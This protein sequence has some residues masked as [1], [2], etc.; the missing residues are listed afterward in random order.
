MEDQSS[1]KQF[2]FGTFEVDVHTGELRKAGVRIRLQ[3]QPFKVLVILLE[4]AGE[5]VSRD[6]LKERLWSASEFGDFDQGINVAIKKI[7]TALGD[8][9]DNPRFVETLARRGYRFIAPVTRNSS[10]PEMVVQS[11]SAPI[12]PPVGRRQP[13]WTYLAGITACLLLLAGFVLLR[14]PHVYSL[15]VLSTPSNFRLAPLTGSLGYEMD[16]Q[17]S[18][19]GKMIAY[20][21]S[22]GEKDSPPNIYVKL[23]GAGN[24]RAL[25]PGDKDTMRALPA[26]SPDGRFIACIRAVRMPLPDF[27][28]KSDKESI[29]SKLVKDREDRKPNAAVYLIPVVGGEEKKLFDVGFITDLKWSPDGKWFLIATREHKSDPVALYRYSP[30]GTERKQLTFPPA[31]FNGDT[32]PAFS[33]DGTLIAFSRNHSSGGSD[34]FIVPSGGGQPRQVTFDAQHVHGITFTGD[35]TQLI[36][37]SAREGGARRALWRVPVNGGHP[38]RLPFGTDNADMPVIDHDGDH[39][40]YVQINPSA[41]IWAYDIPQN[42]AAPGEPKV[43]IGSRQ[44]QVGP[45]YS[46]D[47]NR[48]AFASSRTGSWEIWVS[49]ADG[50]NPIQLTNF[51]DRQTGTPR[52]SYDGKYIAFDA[53]PA[54]RSDIYIID[55]QG[56]TPR[57]LTSGVSDRVVPSFSRD[58]KWVY[59]SSNEGGKWD[60]WKVPFA[61]DSKPVQMTHNGGF[62]AFESVDGKTLYYAKWDK[63]GIYSMPAQGGQETLVTIDNLSGWGCWALVNEGLYFVRPAQKPGDTKQ[64][65]PALA[66]YNFSTRTTTDVRMLNDIPNPGPSIAI[67]PDRKTALYTQPDPGGADIMIVD[68]FR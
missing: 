4:R 58:G 48:I 2:R 68:N 8:E 5:L 51:G 25:V 19:D 43:L 12:L 40:A 24:A 57:A 14:R 13:K 3:D 7:R 45:Q 39:L 30:D 42:G 67:S 44:M 54:Q 33:P 63:P 16:P 64:L 53:R 15:G 66:F 29:A 47:G 46:P 52:W 60:L 31:N 10:T 18:P 23:V 61:G 22:P 1:I 50:S 17:F 27:S 62:S 37:S 28:K 11:T 41:K 6:E 36:F 35:G 34:I 32:V 9:S 20:A 38:V 65:I 49:S 59:Y 21:W 26:W 56:G 55:S